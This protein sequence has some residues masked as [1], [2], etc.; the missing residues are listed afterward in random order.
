MHGRFPLVVR[1]DAAR[2]RA[3]E[4]QGPRTRPPTSSFRPAALLFPGCRRGADRTM[5]LACGP[6]VGLAPAH[7]V[8]SGSSLS[9]AGAA[10]VGSVTGP[11]TAASGTGGRRTG[12]DRVRA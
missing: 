1:I 3:M 12:G 7:G 11:N 8:R 6:E 10:P 5:G 2:P 9:G 4:A